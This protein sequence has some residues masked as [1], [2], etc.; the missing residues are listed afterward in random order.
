[1]ASDYDFLKAS[2]GTGDAALMHITALRAVGSTTVTVDTVSGLPAKFIATSG[3][4]LSTGLLDPVTMTNFKGHTSAGALQID[5]FEPGT[6]DIGNTIGQVVIIKPTTNWANRVAQFI[7]NMTDFG[8]PENV[9][10]AQLTASSVVNTGNGSIAGN[11]T[12]SGNLVV[13]GTSRITAATTVTGAT[14]TPTSQV[15]DVTALNVATTINVPSFGAVNGM[16]AVIRIKDDGTARGITW[17][18]GYQDVSGI[19]LPG[20]TV[21]NKLLTVGALYNTASSKWEVQGINQQA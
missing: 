11:Q 6:P 12:V 16:S 10:V 7:Q 2:D 8:T 13:T 9:T 19:G 3:T 4:L 5:G 18:A 14:I 17:A 21:A 20:A 1:M 15:Y